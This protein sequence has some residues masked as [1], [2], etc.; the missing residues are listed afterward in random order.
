MTGI[1]EIG[2]YACEVFNQDIYRVVIQGK[3]A[4]DYTGRAAEWVS[5][6]QKSIQHLHY[7]S[8]EKDYDLD[9]VLENFNYTKK[10]SLNLNPPSTY[11]PAK[12]P[13]FRVDVL[14]LYVSFWIKLCHL[15]AMDCK[16]IQLRDSKLSSR[17][18]NVFLKHWMA[19]GCSKLK[20]L[21]V[22]VKEPIDYAIVL[23]GVEFTERARDVARV[24]VE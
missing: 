12:P 7:V 4:G 24:Y 17:D 15:L 10:L 5:K 19:G 9:F 3:Q 21:H 20:L 18:L 16:I 23:D 2:Y 13:N 14:Y 11:C 22:S 6:S 8:L 1:A